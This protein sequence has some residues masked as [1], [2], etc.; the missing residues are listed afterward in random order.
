MVVQMEPGGCLVMMV[1]SD[2][3][4]EEGWNGPRRTSEAE[5]RHNLRECAALLLRCQA[6]GATSLGM[7]VT[8]DP[9]Q[10]R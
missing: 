8:A 6:D 9:P 5:I 2:R 3:N 4:P 7:C 10:R 1:M